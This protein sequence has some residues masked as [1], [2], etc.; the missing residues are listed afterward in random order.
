MNG[1]S[2]SNLEVKDIEKF[3][4]SNYSEND[5]LARKIV[6][7]FQSISTKKIERMANIAYLQK[8][9]Y[10]GWEISLKNSDFWYEEYNM[11]FEDE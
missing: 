4:R 9:D 7:A 1:T 3:A 5:D 11:S 6:Q 10:I 2:V 8:L